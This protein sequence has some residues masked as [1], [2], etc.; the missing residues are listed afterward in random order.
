MCRRTG[1]AGAGLVH[2]SATNARCTVYRRCTTCRSAH[3]TRGTPAAGTLGERSEPIRTTAG[4]G[5]ARWR[6]IR[7][8]IPSNAPFC[9]HISEGQRASS[10]V[11]PS[12]GRRLLPGVWLV[13]GWGR[14]CGWSG[15]AAGGRLGSGPAGW[16]RGTGG[17][18]DGG[19]VVVGVKGC[20]LGLGGTRLGGN[21]WWGGWRGGWF[22]RR[23]LG[24]WLPGGSGGGS[25]SRW[26]F[27]WGREVRR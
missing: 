25:G 7:P 18:Y 5:P 6:C 10:G 14:A 16:L 12:N 26:G 2:L 3:I 24:S 9:A 4:G 22:G 13:V 27:G 11:I 23:E 20:V 1:S 21:W 15:R 19:R 8:D 17:G